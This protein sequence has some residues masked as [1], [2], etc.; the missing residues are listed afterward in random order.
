[1]IAI[2]MYKIGVQIVIDT[3]CSIYQIDSNNNDYIL[4]LFS[5]IYTYIT[6]RVDDMSQMYIRN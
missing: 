1:M 2:V 3:L 4:N 5:V 6:I